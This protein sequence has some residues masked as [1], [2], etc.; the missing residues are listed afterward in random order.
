MLRYIDADLGQGKTHLL[1]LLRLAAFKSDFL[2]SIVELSVSECPLYKMVDVYQR[3]I[4]GLRTR[5][6]RHEPALGSV[7]ERW[8]ELQRSAD[9]G[10]R[11]RVL[12]RLPTA[13]RAA[14]LAYLHATNFLDPS[15]LRSDLVLRWLAGE[16][17]PLRQRSALQ[18]TEN[19][20]D[21]TALQMLGALAELARDIGYAGICVLFDEAEAMVS[22]SRSTQRAQA[23]TNI[24]RVVRAVE[25]SPGIYF[26]YAATPSFFDLVDVSQ[27]LQP[28][29]SDG[30]VLTPQPLSISDLS[31]LADRIAE[32]HSVAYSWIPPIDMMKSVVTTLSVDARISD[33]TKRLVAALDELHEQL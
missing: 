23:L 18:L 14:L 28:R 24:V 15:A 32:V 9:P 31:V 26:V 17:L 22:F 7:L 33:T 1:N 30:I 10:A 20:A 29:T 27:K 6:S 13:M 2:V 25:Q 16:S 4:E 21:H 12:D 5:S 11:K 19:I 8:L 3:I